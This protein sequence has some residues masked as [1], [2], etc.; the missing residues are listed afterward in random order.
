L[1]ASHLFLHLAGR[2]ASRERLAIFA[3]ALFIVAILVSGS[4]WIMFTLNGRMMPDTAQMEQYM[5]DQ[6]GF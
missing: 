2:G 1:R 6:S 5:N 3:A 4:L